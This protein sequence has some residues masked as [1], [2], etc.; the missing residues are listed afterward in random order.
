MRVIWYPMRCSIWNW[1]RER[2][3]RLRRMHKLHFV[4]IPPRKV[5]KINGKLAENTHIVSNIVRINCVF[6]CHS[7]KCKLIR[8]DTRCLFP[9]KRQ[10]LP[11]VKQILRGGAV[12]GKCPVVKVVVI[13]VDWQQKWIF[14][15]VELI[16]IFQ[17]G[18]KNFVCQE[19]LDVV[20][21]L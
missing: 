12:D 5:L 15:P 16:N 8:Y 10:M 1:T 3:K 6:S 18:N 21:K 4:S 11:I 9:I 13:R 14:D 20:S 17:A 19:S 2:Q 7:L